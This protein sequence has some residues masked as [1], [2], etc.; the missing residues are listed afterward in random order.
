MFFHANHTGSRAKTTIE[1]C[2]YLLT[3][4]KNV[5]NEILQHGACLGLS[6]AEFG[7]AQQTLSE[8]SLIQSDNTRTD[9]RT[10]LTPREAADMASGSI[11]CAIGTSNDWCS[12]R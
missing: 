6:L 5:S 3:Q 2:N 1:N 12:K 8:E 7:F 10:I 11:L 4:L 9:A